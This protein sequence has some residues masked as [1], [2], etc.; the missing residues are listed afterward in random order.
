MSDSQAKSKSLLVEARR[1]QARFLAMLGMGVGINADELKGA[2]AKRQETTE[3]AG[4][5]D[6]ER[7]DKKDPKD[8][9]SWWGRKGHG[10]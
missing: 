10:K 7:K 3:R 8:K 1:S 4:R 5:D 6:Q 2:K 9:K